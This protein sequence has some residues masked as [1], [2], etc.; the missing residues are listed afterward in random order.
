MNP[1][2]VEGE[3]ISVHARGLEKDRGRQTS[4]HGTLL[5]LRAAMVAAAVGVLLILGTGGAQRAQAQVELVLH[6]FTG[7]PGDGADPVAGLVEDSSGGLYGTTRDGGSSSFGTVFKLTASS[8]YTSEMVLHSFTGA[9]GDGENPL[10]GLVEDSSGN[11]YG[12]TESGGTSTHCTGGCGTV[13]ELSRPTTGSTWTESVLHSFTGKLGGDGADPDAGLVMDPN[14]GN[15]YGTTRDGGSSGVGSVFGISPPTTGSTWTESLLYSFAG[16]SV[17]DGA[18]PVAGLVMDPNTGNLYGTTRVG[19]LG[20]G[21]VFELIPPTTGSTWTESVLYSFTG[22]SGDGGNPVAGLVMD[23][24]TGDLYGTTRDGGSSGFGTVFKLTASSGYTSEMV[25]YSFAGKSVGDGANPE[26]GLVMDP[27]TGDLYGTTRVGGSSG[28][29]TVF[30]VAT[31]PKYETGLIVDDVNAMY[32]EGVLN[33]GQDG[34]LVKELNDAISGI[35]AGKANKAIG[36][37][38]SFVTEVND[39]YNSGI[40]NESEWM[41][42]V[43]DAN[44]VITQLQAM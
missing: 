41:E 42:L 30:V 28:P 25:L 35:N 7:T 27:N 22:A 16:K 10:G 26:A 36:N 40:L 24:K 8:G 33:K 2:T 18:N 20:P 39:L 5:P 4:S 23:P 34:S 37:L 14:T 21:T 6:S 44:T 43:N 38:E 11:L 1:S 17:G 31:K 32:T 9:S 15:L 29:G 13:F 12:T 3:G 19:G